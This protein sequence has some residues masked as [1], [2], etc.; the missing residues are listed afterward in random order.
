VLGKIEIKRNLSFTDE[1]G[2][3]LRLREDENHP[4][5]RIMS[6]GLMLALYHL[7]Q[8]PKPFAFSVCFPDRVSCFC[9]G[10]L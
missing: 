1:P 3:K 10:L 6:L 8:T 5:E 2:K 4:S 7:S 9:L